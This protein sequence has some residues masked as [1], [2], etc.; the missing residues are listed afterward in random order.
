MLWSQPGQLVG[1]E[2]SHGR[3]DT[4]GG[5]HPWVHFFSREKSPGASRPLV[6]ESR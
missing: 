1:G 5:D 6:I 2:A 4:L 3:K